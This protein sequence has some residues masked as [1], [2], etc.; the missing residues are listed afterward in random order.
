MDGGMMGILKDIVQSFT[1]YVLNNSLEIDKSTF[2][3]IVIGQIAIYGILLTFYQFVASYKRSEKAATRY[4][5]I[6]VTEYFIMKNVSAFNKIVSKKWF[7]FMFVLEI[8][9]KPITV[10]FNNM[11]SARLSSVINFVWYV[12][13]IFYFV[14]FVILFFQCTKCIL[15]IKFC[16]DAKTNG[17]IIRDINK[18]FL[19]KNWHER[20]NKYSVELLN[21]D[22]NDLRCA[23][24]SDD[25]SDLQPRYNH[26][27]YKIFNTY[28]QQKSD[29]IEKIQKDS[30]IVKNQIPWIYN[31]NSEIHLL[32]EILDE[33]C[34][35]FDNE[36]IIF[37]FHIQLL[38]LNLKR[39]QLAG[40]QKISCK[41][42]E[43]IYRKTGE[44]V[45]DVSDWKEVTLKIYSK[46][47]D[48]L[49]KNL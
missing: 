3:T 18:M 31:S 34:F 32:Q 27:I 17:S 20:L 9:Y 30:K 28:I 16:S 48:K 2:L 12:F 26:L 35:I 29:E 38:Q 40:Y 45:F 7:G 19:Q 4:L 37:L 1:Y 21:E 8:L 23:I 6:N 24:E 46:M 22:F 5:G 33:E 15:V 43:R 13:V 25:N 10:I 44:K 41:K 42:Y 36:K 47:N 11:F 39:A 14:I 49:K